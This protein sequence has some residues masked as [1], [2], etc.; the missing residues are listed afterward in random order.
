MQIKYILIFL[1]TD[2]IYIRTKIRTKT[3]VEVLVRKHRVYFSARLVT[4]LASPRGGQ[5]ALNLSPEG[6]CVGG[7][8]H[9][10]SEEKGIP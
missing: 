2:S 6:T 1:K 9:Q 8:P 5:Y 7:C 10:L 4:L 3:M